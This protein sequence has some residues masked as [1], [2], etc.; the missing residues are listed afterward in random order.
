MFNGLLG[1]AVAKRTRNNLYSIYLA[2]RLVQQRLKERGIIYICIKS[3][4]FSSST[5]LAW[6]WMTRQQTSQTSRLVWWMIKS[7]H[8]FCSFVGSIN[9]E[10]ERF[11]GTTKVIFNKDVMA[12]RRDSTIITPIYVNIFRKTNRKQRCNI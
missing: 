12:I 3:Y 10:N 11:A 7:V 9:E 4:I 1:S 2:A 5:R 6:Q 8:E